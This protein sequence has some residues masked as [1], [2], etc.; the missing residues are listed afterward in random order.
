MDG[1]SIKTDDFAGKFVIVDMFAT[2]CKPCI[3]EMSLIKT[4]YEKYK[5]KGLVVIGISLDEDRQKLEEF[6]AGSPLP[7]P[8]VHDNAENPLD[9][10]QL[11]YGVS[12]LPTVLLLNKEGTVVSL[13]ARNAEQSRLMQMLFEAP[14]PAPPQTKPAEAAKP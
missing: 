9:R 1:K 10:L 6:L 14:T 2:W 11:K 8:I 5:D 3:E 12:A 13:E 7:W 4:H